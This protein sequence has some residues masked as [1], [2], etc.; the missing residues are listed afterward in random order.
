MSAESPKRAKAPDKARGFAKSV[1]GDLATRTNATIAGLLALAG[2]TGLAGGFEEAEPEGVVKVAAPLG[3]Q[4]PTELKVKPLD[5]VIQRTYVENQKR[6]FEVQVTNTSSRPIST[7]YDRIFTL[8]DSNLPGDEQPEFPEKFFR[9]TPGEPIP[10]DPIS[11]QTIL[12]PGVQY[13]LWIVYS[14]P[15]DGS[16]PGSAEAADVWL[17]ESQEYKASILEAMSNGFPGL[18]PRR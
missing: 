7:S 6:V 1:A 2:V 3:P 18:P 10:D 8:R 9:L 17:L 12:N 5:I 13:D 4:E 16:A 15:L 11:D 14:D